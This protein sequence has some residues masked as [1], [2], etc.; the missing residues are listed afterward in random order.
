M[1]KGLF[2]ANSFVLGDSQALRDEIDG[3]LGNELAI[4]YFLGVYGVN[5]L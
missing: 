2:P 3:K 5:E 1:L 4:G